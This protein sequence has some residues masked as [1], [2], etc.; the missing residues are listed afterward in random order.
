MCYARPF[1]K[2]GRMY[3]KFTPQSEENLNVSMLLFFDFFYVGSMEDLT[4]CGRS[5]FPPWKSLKKY[6]FLFQI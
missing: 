6:S 5:I 3:L 2:F 4:T 1:S